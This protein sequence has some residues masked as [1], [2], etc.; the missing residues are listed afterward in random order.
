MSNGGELVVRTL[1]EAEVDLVFGLHGAHIDTVF[2][3]ALDAGLR[4]ID[5]RSEAGAGHAAEGYSRV[6]R[7]LGVALVTA[8]GGFTNVL[9]SIANAWLDRTPV[10]YLTGSGALRDSET[11]TLQAG[12]DQVA[13]ATP[14]TKWAYRVTKADQIPRLVA[15]AIRVATSA[16]RGPVLLDIPWDILLEEVAD[17]SS[18][19]PIFQA[20]GK[21]SL[22]SKTI[23]RICDILRRAKRPAIV[24]GGEAG[25][26]GGKKALERLVEITGIPAF[27]DYEGLG[28]LAGLGDADGGLVQGLFTFQSADLAPDAVLM[29]TRFGLTTAHGSGTLIPRGAEI[30]H[31]D[32][33]AR[34][35]GRLQSVTMPVVADP[36]EALI[37]LGEA[38]PAYEWPVRTEWRE[39]VALLLRSRYGAAIIN[40]V[41]EANAIHPAR[42]SEIVAESLPEDSIVVA[43]GALTYLW[44]T[45]VVSRAR[46]S[47]FLCHGYLGSM[48]IGMGTAMG[49]QAA[50][51]TVGRRTVLVTGDGSVGYALGEFDAMK[52]AGLPVV[53]VVMNNRSWGATQH[54]QELAVGPNRVTGTRLENGE[55]HLAAQAMGARGYICDTEQGLQEAL[56]EAFSVLEP[57]CINVRVQLSPIPPEERVIMGQAPF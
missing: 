36:S 56:R 35:L 51:N 2:Q 9:T 28:L 52:R 49:A 41:Q 14:V 8:G 6:S 24:V 17:D 46:P 42:A 13:M 32:A 4:I 23:D 43:D 55:Y 45:E 18:T 44:F 39:Q 25:H 37:A 22:A 34:E 10:L 33:D 27:A 31:I 38:A 53:V 48:G 16:P 19:Q 1:R 20:I 57:A 7:K 26:G 30:I 3:A 54:F 50:A 12:I 21:A 47:A 15:Q 5:T 11:N 40:A 29:L